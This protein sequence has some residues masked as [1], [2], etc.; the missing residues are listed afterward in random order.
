[1]I[2]RAQPA[3]RAAVDAIVAAAYSV[4]V[5]RIG[6][7][8]GPMLDDYAKLIDAGA[9]SVFEA[10]GAIAALIVLLPKPDHLLLDNVAVRPDR[11]GQG[12]GRRLVDF[13]ESEAQRL[14]FSEL[15]LYTHAMMTENIALYTRLGFRETG[16]GREAGY[17]RVFMAK[18]LSGPDAGFWRC[19]T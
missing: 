7:P 12:L 17:D 9:V 14:G 2:R 18:P 13:A 16:R 10:D 5:A 3:D 11:Q 4:Y 8:P 6:K 1:V 15:R 19:Y